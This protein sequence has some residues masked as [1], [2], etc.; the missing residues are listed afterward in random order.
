M[1]GGAWRRSA[2]P[3]RSR[4]QRHGPTDHGDAMVGSVLSPL[5]RVLAPE[6]EGHRHR[7]SAGADSTD[8]SLLSR[9]I[10]FWPGSECN[11]PS[12][13]S[14]PTR[15][16]PC[17]PWSGEW[18]ARRTASS[19]TQRQTIVLRRRVATV[20]GRHQSAARLCRWHR[21]PNEAPHV[22]TTTYTLCYHC[23]SPLPLHHLP[24]SH[25]CPPHINH[26]HI[27]LSNYCLLH[28]F[29]YHCC[30]QLPSCCFPLGRW[31]P[32]FR[33]TFCYVAAHIYPPR[34]FPV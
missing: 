2:A 24:A 25:I 21:G 17:E 18:T 34:S 28:I 19:W 27:F 6:P 4:V 23:R 31:S 20:C 15:S 5:P 29:S 12:T 30:S 10:E 14:P 11:N 26:H 33:N 22:G 32:L 1:S 16:S 13:S 9:S 8:L 7:H 3:V